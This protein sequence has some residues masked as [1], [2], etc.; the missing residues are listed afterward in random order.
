MMQSS[1]F[2]STVWSF[3]H[4]ENAEIE[5]SSLYLSCDSMQTYFSGQINC[6]R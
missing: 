2:I 4:G 5:M 1:F 3:Y 6:A